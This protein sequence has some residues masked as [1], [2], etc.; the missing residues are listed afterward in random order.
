MEI[1]GKD[2][3]IISD[4]DA[5]KI[6]KEWERP[7]VF[8]DAVERISRQNGYG[9]LYAAVQNNFYGFDINGMGAPIPQSRDNIGYTFYTR[10]RMNLSYHNVSLDRRMLPLTTRDPYSTRMAIR[11]LLDPIANKGTWA[12]KMTLDSGAIFETITTPLIDPKNC[13]IP[14]LSNN[15]LTMSGWPDFTADTYSSVE[16]RQREQWSMYDGPMRMLGLYDFTTTFRNIA[17]DAISTLLHMWL[18]YGLN[19]R[20]GK[21]WPYPDANALNEK[22]YETACYRIVMDPTKTYVMFIMR[23]IMFPTSA[24]SGI[25]GNFN[26]ENPIITESGQVSLQWRGQGVEVQDPILVEEFNDVVQM[27]NY[28]MRLTDPTNPNSTLVG[29]EAGDYSKVSPAMKNVSNYRCY[30]RINPISMELE[31]YVD[32]N[33]LGDAAIY[34]F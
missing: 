9:E 31:W 28:S 19:V 7:S 17:T 21:M 16:G 27:F 3:P 34:G 12:N 10:P 15:L 5:E 6:G 14:L 1:N 2:V 24:P 25:H 32:L 11:A 26:K 20:N 33:A 13:F 18:F 22:D 8:R 4:E 30:P 29:V 23:S